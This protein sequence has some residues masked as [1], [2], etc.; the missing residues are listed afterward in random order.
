LQLTELGVA[1]D[2][3]FPNP[4]DKGLAGQAE[5]LR[6][7]LS[8]TAQNRHRWRIAGVD[9]FTWQDSDVADP[10]CVFCEFAGLFDASGEPKPAWSV[11]RRLAGR[12]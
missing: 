1:S 10:H 9:W 3:V 11:F 6:R 2:G 7:A 12:R 4:F 8:L 5:F